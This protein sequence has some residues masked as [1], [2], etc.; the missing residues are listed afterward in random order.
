MSARHLENRPGLKA[1]DRL[2][3]FENDLTGEIIEKKDEVGVGLVQDT[4]TSNGQNFLRRKKLAYSQ[5][6]ILREQKE[7][8]KKFCTYG[9]SRDEVTNTMRKSLKVDKQ[10]MDPLDAYSRKRM[11]VLAYSA[12]QVGLSSLAKANKAR[13][14][15]HL[16]DYG[17]VGY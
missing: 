10:D 4:S 3:D 13:A 15:P 16:S 11:N 12:Q 14:K 7:I 9:G 8:F 1:P 5:G 6:K 2:Q 17:G